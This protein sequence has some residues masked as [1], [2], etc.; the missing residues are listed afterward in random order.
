MLQHAPR[1]PLKSLPKTADYSPSSHTARARIA[2]LMQHARLRAVT[3][4]PERVDARQA[5]EDCLRQL[6]FDIEE[7][8]AMI[9]VGPLPEVVADAQRLPLLFYCLLSNA[10]TFCTDTPQIVVS[11]QRGGTGWQFSVADHGI[12]IDARD[13]ERILDVFHRLHPQ[14]YPGTGIGLTLARRIVS[15]HGGSLWTES[16]LRDGAR[17]HFTLPDRNMPFS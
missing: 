11:A 1:L 5:V 2:G 12:G 8:G 6:A 13:H 14:D 16:A 3:M 10:L 9:Q 15:M 17:F 4:Q 7:R